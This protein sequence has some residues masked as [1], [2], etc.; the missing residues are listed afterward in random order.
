MRK[1]YLLFFCV[2]VFSCKKSKPQPEPEPVYH[3][4]KTIT[5]TGGGTSYHIDLEYKKDTLIAFKASNSTTSYKLKYDKMGRI[6]RFQLYDQV[7]IKDTS[8]I[9]YHPVWIDPVF[10]RT[11]SVIRT[12]SMWIQGNIC[13][14]ELNKQANT[15]KVTVKEPI[16][17]TTTQV[18]DATLDGKRLLSIPSQNKTYTW[19]SG[20]N[21][22][23][24]KLSFWYF[25]DMP[26]WLMDLPN[27]SKETINGIDYLYTYEY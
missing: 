10:N 9:E 7:N 24:N 22:N 12:G 3:N 14:F 19:N 21:S 13:F 26:V 15:L 11:S 8:N 5:V 27:L 23:P 4:V 1:I 17:N 25:P 18:I 16:N 6:E 20:L 2:I